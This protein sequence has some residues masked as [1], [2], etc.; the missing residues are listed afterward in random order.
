MEGW[1]DKGC[2]AW[3]VERGAIEMEGGRDGEMDTNKEDARLWDARY[4]V[5]GFWVEN[6]RPPSVQDAA[7]ELGVTVDEARALYQELNGRHALML[8]AG[9]DAIRMANPFSGVPTGFRVSV[10]DRKYYAN[11]AWDTFGIPA[12]L[13]SDATMTAFCS[14][15]LEPLRFAVRDGKVS[16]DAAVVYFRVPFAK[17]YDDLVFT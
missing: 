3:R 16:G 2:G 11:C 12:A 5:Y 9:T 17:W 15:T 13:H 7:R 14:N 6:E 8:M 1:R 4:F 10:G